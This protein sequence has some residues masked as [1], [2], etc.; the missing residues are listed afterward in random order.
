MQIL[1]R[2]NATQSGKP[3]CVSLPV[4]QEEKRHHYFSSFVQAHSFAKNHQIKHGWPISDH[5]KLTG[6]E[7]LGL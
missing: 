1:I 4:G 7:W 5:I 3:Y 2:K 6:Y